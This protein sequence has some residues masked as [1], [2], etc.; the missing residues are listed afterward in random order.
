MS[1]HGGPRVRIVRG[2]SYG[3]AEDAAAYTFWATS[4]WATGFWA[5]GFWA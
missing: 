5:D 2:S 1:W 4:L 3:S